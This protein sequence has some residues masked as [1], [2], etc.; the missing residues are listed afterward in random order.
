MPQ[1]GKLVTRGFLPVEL[2]LMESNHVQP[3][4]D[5]FVAFIWE[6]MASAVVNELVL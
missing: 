4:N 3:R 5:P 6:A 1:A 2:A